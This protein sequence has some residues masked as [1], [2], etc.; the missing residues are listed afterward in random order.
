MTGLLDAEGVEWAV[1]ADPGSISSEQMAAVI[2][3]LHHDN[4]P[5]QPLGE[6]K[7]GIVKP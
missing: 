3:H 2:S 4:R 5:V 6:R 1:L 7:I